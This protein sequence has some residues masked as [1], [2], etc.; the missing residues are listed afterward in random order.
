MGEKNSEIYWFWLRSVQKYWHGSDLFQP[1]CL[2]RA[3]RRCTS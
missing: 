3:S 1:A 2:G